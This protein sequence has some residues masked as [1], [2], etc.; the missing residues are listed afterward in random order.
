MSEF[1]SLCR[2]H[3]IPFIRLKLLKYCLNLIFLFV[4]E[5][6]EAVTQFMLCA[7][8][9]G[10]LLLILIGYLF[11]RQ[12][13]FIIRHTPKP[14]RGRTLTLCGIYTIVGAAALTSLI[15]YRAYVFCDSVCHF[16]FLMCAYQYFTLIIDYADGESNFIKNTNGSMVFNM[17]TPPL[18]CCLPFLKP[19]VITKYVICV[20]LQLIIS[21]HISIP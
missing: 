3:Q 12:M 15:A 10:T 11:I 21:C 2:L 8:V 17:R 13:P 16:A 7:I 14:Y 5:V 18:C 6:S 4:F 1:K 20:M 19:T 9:I